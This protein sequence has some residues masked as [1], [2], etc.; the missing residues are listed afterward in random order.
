MHCLRVV[1]LSVWLHGS[2]HD[3]LVYSV[4]VGVGV[5]LCWSVWLWMG[6]CVCVVGR[7][8]VCAV[9]RACGIIRVWGV[10]CVYAC[11][12]GVLWVH[13]RRYVCGGVYGGLC[14]CVVRV[15][16]VARDDALK[17]TH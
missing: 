2:V 7:L 15:C 14:V 17:V 4:Y 11:M 6:S 1:A 16:C 8:G 5:V 10:G 3:L 13:V 12:R 9:V